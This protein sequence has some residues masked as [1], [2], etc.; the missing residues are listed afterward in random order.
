[1][2]EGE[3]FL[4]YAF[5]CLHINVK[6]DLKTKIES[7]LFSDTDLAFS[8]LEEEILS[9]FQRPIEVLERLA[10]ERGLSWYHESL[11]REYFL[12]RHNK[13]PDTLPRCRGYVG[14]VED[15]SEEEGVPIYSIKYEYSCPK[16]PKKVIGLL[17]KKE[18]VG[19]GDKIAI[20]FG[21][22][23]EKLEDE[24]YLKYRK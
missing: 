4:R 1:M 11:V 23:V 14:V 7:F 17:T 3:L 8:D 9:A 20:H 12:E 18:E 21:H 19:K 15:V 16:A 22:A 6:E 10:K 5:G 2:K 24:T 13:Q